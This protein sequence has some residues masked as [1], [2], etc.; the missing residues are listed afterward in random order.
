MN[1]QENNLLLLT[2][3]Q[4][5]EDDEGNM[6]HIKT[7]S[8]G[9]KYITAYF[10]PKPQNGVL[11]NARE[12]G[13]NIWEQG[14]NGSAGDSIFPAVAAANVQPN[15]FLSRPLTVKGDIQTVETEPFYIPS[16]YG[17]FNDPATGQPA[18]KATQ[19]TSVVFEDENIVSLARSQEG[20][21]VAGE[22]QAEALEEEVGELA[23]A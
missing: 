11:S 19:Y 20:I 14:P 17:K 16:E 5:T 6:T 8:D 2:R 15:G 9:R 21:T 7:S 22:A 18:N 4:M 12:R 23:T 1:N 10:K 13:R 3:V